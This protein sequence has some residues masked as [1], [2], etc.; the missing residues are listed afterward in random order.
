M[1]KVISNFHLENAIGNTGDEDLNNNFVGVFPS[2]C[3]NKFIN[4]SAMTS[5]KKGKYPFVIA[6]TESSEKEGTH[7]WSIIDIDP[8]TD[9]FF[10]DSF[11]AD[12]LKHFII[13]NDRNIIEKILFGTEK[14][15]RTDDKITFCNIRFNLNAC[16]NLSVEEI[17][18]LSDTA[19]NFFCFNQAFSNKLKLRNS[20]NIWMVEDRVQDLNSATCGI[21][22]LY[23]YDNLFNPNENSKIQGKTKLNK[24]AIE[25][26]LNELFVI[27][28]QD[29]SKETIRQYAQNTEISVT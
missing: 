14:M 8:K 26:L 3:M 11:G 21:F 28:N 27:D 23:F 17:G 5:S 9:I 20:V 24:K 10:F 4:H 18:A 19:S 29:K 6:N 1:S 7:W 13:Q 15:T 2:N 25:T 16:K 12:S 22:Q